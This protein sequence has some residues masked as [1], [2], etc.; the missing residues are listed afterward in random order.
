MYIKPHKLYKV[1]SSPTQ[2]DDKGN[3]IASTCDRRE[4]ISG[5]F[6]HNIG[7][8]EKKG[9]LGQGI[10]VSYFVNIDRNSELS[11]GMEVLVMDGDD[12]IGKGKI[13][14]IKHTSGHINN[15][16]TIYI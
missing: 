1:V 16:T 9:Y 8:Q 13:E 4:Y 10:S 6:L 11:Y 2:V 3:P 15:Y 7:I 5:C 12:I 14:D